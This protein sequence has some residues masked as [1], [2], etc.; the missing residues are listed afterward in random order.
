[1]G[2]T[3]VGKIVKINKILE[4]SKQSTDKE[5]D[6]FEK[7]I[8]GFTEINNNFS[9]IKKN[10]TNIF[11]SKFS[12]KDSNLRISTIKDFKIIQGIMNKESGTDPFK[13]YEKLTTI[14]EN[15]NGNI[16]KVCHKQTGLIRAMKIIEKKLNLIDEDLEANL[17]KEFNILKTFDHPNII[18]VIEYFSTS[19]ELYFI[20]EYCSG[21][22]L[23]DKI[24]K[25]TSFSEKVTAHIMRQIFSAIL[26]CHQN[27]IIHR[28]LKPENI[29]IESEKESK[30]E[31]FNIKIID[32]C[33]C[34]INI[35]KNMLTK[36]IGAPYYIAP[37][38]LT[39]SYN[40]K[41]DI[42]SCGVIMYILL[43]GQPP[44]NAENDQEILS[45]VKEGKFSM[46]EKLWKY[47][48]K[49]AKD[50]IKRLLIKDITKRISAEQAL[51]H[52]WFNK[53]EQ[54]I[55]EN[56]IITEYQIHHVA[57]NLKNF[58]AFKKLQQAALAYIVRNI[59]KLE[60]TEEYRKIFRYFD[61]DGDGRLSKEEFVKGFNRVML[62]KEAQA[63]VE[64]FIA[65]VD[66]D[67][68]GYIEY[69]EFLIGAMDKERILS[70]RNL[71]KVF[72]NFDSDS[73][74]KISKKEIK[75]L[76]GKECEKMV[77]DKVWEEVVREMDVDG[78]GEVEFNEFVDLM[79]KLIDYK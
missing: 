26:L 50:L 35:D 67:G 70:Y 4:N 16:L 31:F 34:E 64:N 10:K 28:D 21:G 9:P 51:A 41:C 5:D 74:G 71:K 43:S 53:M 60:E 55:K 59:I 63:V 48:S 19:N 18:K 61:L 27:N 65:L 37:E 52:P 56:F 39:K 11:E 25:E 57:Q 2:C 78:D 20:S 45:L 13:Y 79:N 49:D 69:E 68:N 15:S 76:F 54:K 44:F 46:K 40:E 29:L 1:M 66:I 36:K 58:D 3:P 14:Y 24:Q 17:I 22:E 72:H 38:I 8:N 12:I 30:K 62:H 6:Y 7:K 77:T 23:F 42:W 73:S 32:F 33:R 47:V 75:N